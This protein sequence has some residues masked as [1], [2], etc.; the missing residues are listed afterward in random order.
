MS[1]LRSMNCLRPVTPFLEQ[2]WC[3]CCVALLH[4]A[5]EMG[6]K[7]H[8]VCAPCKP[9]PPLAIDVS[10]VSETHCNERDELASPGGKEP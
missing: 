7:V 1:T 9:P 4:G 8:V 3:A 10:N 6:E 2:G 5:S